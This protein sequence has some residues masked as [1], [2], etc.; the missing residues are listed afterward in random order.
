MSQALRQNLTAAVINQEIIKQHLEDTKTP[1][2]KYTPEVIIKSSM[3]YSGEVV[4]KQKINKI[5][6]HLAQSCK[7][8]STNIFGNIVHD[9]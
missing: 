3:V 5:F 8:F 4:S 7:V 2:Y 1:Y 9:Q 6:N